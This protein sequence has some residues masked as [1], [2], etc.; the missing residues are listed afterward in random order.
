MNRFNIKSNIALVFLIFI[1]PVL[2]IFLGNFFACSPEEKGQVIKKPDVNILIVTLDTTRADRIGIY[3]C[4]ESKTPHM[5]NLARAGA[6]FKNVY[7]PVPLTLPAHCSLFTGT[8]PLFHNVR[9]NGK[10]LLS[11]ELE[12]LAEIFK[13]K[14]YLTSAFV[15]SFIVD[16]RFGL[17][18]GFDVYND[19]LKLDR[20]VKVY[21]SE[22][23]A[24]WVYKDFEQ[25]L[26][27][28]S[29]QKFF[30]WVHFFDPHTPYAP[31][32]PFKSQFFSD[33]YLGEIA[34]VDVY[35]GKIVDKLRFL[36]V[37]DNTM[38]IIVG[39]HG[40]AFGEHKEYGHRVF[41]YDENLKVPLI[42]Y[43]KDHLPKKCFTDRVK[44]I[45]IFPTILDFLDY[46]LS[47]F[48]QGIS[49][50]PYLNGKEL[51]DRSFYFESYFVMEDLGCAPLAGIIQ[52]DYKFIDLPQSELYDLRKDPLESENMVRRKPRLA[53]K[54][55]KEKSRLVNEFS[56][57]VRSG[58]KMTREERKRLESLGYLSTGKDSAKS[59]KM[60]DPKEIIE[61]YN[62]FAKGVSFLEQ[63]NLD[64]AES[65]FKQ[66]I[67]MAPFFAEA[68][69]FLSSL[70]QS[71]GEIPRALA[72]L[73]EGL[74]QDPDNYNIKLKYARILIQKRDLD[75]ALFNLKDLANKDDIDS[76]PLV[77]FLI[78]NI[79][80]HKKFFEKAITHYRI[81]LEVESDN[82]S[83]KKN[84]AYSLLHLGRRDEALKVYKE[85]ETQEPEDLQLLSDL[86]VLFAQMGE[87]DRADEYF[88]KIINRAPSSN[89]L[90]NYAL[91]LA[92]KNEYDR[93]VKMMNRF[94]SLYNKIDS[95]KRMAQQ[96]IREW[97][98]KN[99]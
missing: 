67:N 73:E 92:K 19:R 2:I 35:V 39:D 31:P 80:L 82:K 29:K 38:I 85:L 47:E 52:G 42:F 98:I 71:R 90:F 62:L 16:S 33:P 25:W 26:I 77:N 5:D 76:Q 11:G 53:K 7:S 9:N 6:W 30:S 45:D 54:L 18:Q 84:L 78:G 70:Y 89:V 68:Y 81:A 64:K 60:C 48:V 32:E 12:T 3:G 41:C 43:L 58:R 69:V 75:T 15:S 93:A 97:Q 66:V 95:R 86:A 17:N 13:K 24:E 8:Y 46:P 79:Y 63:E 23:P 51:I 99:R 44:I 74:K 36:G 87:Y 1:F 49:L 83:I 94:L 61:S 20:Q 34:Y 21:R 56:Q 88:Q 28:N 57:E 55:K 10:Y 96:Y 40:E 14:G 37:L 27:K 59:G 72:V 4:K 22:R 50:I 65:Y 91:L